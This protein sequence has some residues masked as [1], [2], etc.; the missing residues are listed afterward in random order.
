MPETNLLYSRTPLTLHELRT[1]LTDAQALAFT[2]YGE[3]RTEPIEG[4]IALGCL[5]RNRSR[6]QK[7]LWGT[8]IVA[9]CLAQHGFGCWYAWGGEDNHAHLQQLVVAFLRGGPIPWTAHERACYTEC[10]WITEGIL[11]DFVLD[12]VAGATQSYVP[13]VGGLPAWAVGQPEGVRV[14]GVVYGQG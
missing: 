8:T 7:R 6:A 12:R 9:V 1:R 2:L 4:R 3:S 11:S 13:G 10:C 14:A 5:I